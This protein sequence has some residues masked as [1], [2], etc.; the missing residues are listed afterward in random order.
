[1]PSLSLSHTHNAGMD[2]AREVAENI[3]QR[4]ADAYDVRYQWLGDHIEFERSGISGQIR[5]N[6]EEIIVDARM[7]MMLGMFRSQIEQA[8][9]DELNQAFV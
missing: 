1:M 2:R 5:I 4:I 3:A 9:Q 7:N 6:A 8:I